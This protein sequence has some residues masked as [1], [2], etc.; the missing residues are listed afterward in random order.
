MD[1]GGGEGCRYGE[2]GEDIDYKT[3][4]FVGEETES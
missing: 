2:E 3:P 1:V 4:F